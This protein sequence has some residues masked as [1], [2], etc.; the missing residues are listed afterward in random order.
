MAR[1]PQHEDGDRTDLDEVDLE[2][3]RDAFIEAFNARDL[4]TIL[5]IVAEDVEIPDL[6]GEGRGDLSDE[7]ESL[8]ED[9]PGVILTRA[10]VDDSP[11]AV[12]W[13]PTDDGWSRW[14]LFTFDD[15]QG[16]LTVVEMPDDPDDLERA[17][18]ESPEDEPPDEEVTW[19]EW[20]RAEDIRDVSYPLHPI[21]PIEDG[22]EEQ[23]DDEAAPDTAANR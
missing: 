2:S 16:L 13:L 17:V 5:D 7:L 9:F 10:S 19:P 15:D 23:P 3:L 11:S 12:A 20:D 22:A 21:D 14:L 1:A 8:W 18:A 4:E 6:L